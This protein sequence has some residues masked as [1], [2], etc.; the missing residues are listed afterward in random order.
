MLIAV[1]RGREMGQV[2][3]SGS[4][5]SWSQLDGGRRRRQ[6]TIRRRDSAG[7]ADVKKFSDLQIF[8]FTAAAFFRWP[9]SHLVGII[10]QCHGKKNFLPS[11][12]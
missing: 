4:G 9:F 1:M 3:L 2:F 11:A 5:Q 6:E 12:E 10:L 8:P 7:F